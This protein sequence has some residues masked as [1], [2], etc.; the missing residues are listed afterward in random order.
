MRR[1]SYVAATAF[2]VCT[3]AAGARSFIVPH[4]IESSGAT[5]SFSTTLYSAY[6]GGLLGGTTGSAPVAIYLYDQL[7]EQPAQSLTNQDVCN[8]CSYQHN[9]HLRHESTASEAA[10]L[11]AGGFAS[12][13]LQG[14]AIVDVTGDAANV[15]LNGFLNN[16]RS[17]VFDFSSL[18]YAPVEIVS[19]PEAGPR[20]FV[21]PHLFESSATTS[22]P[23]AFDSSLYAVYAGGLPGAPPAGAGAQVALYLLDEDTQDFARSASFQQVCNPCTY[24]V[25]SGQRKARMS[26]QNAFVAAG[27]FPSSNARCFAVLVITG[28]A[29]L[30][31]IQGLTL[32]SRSS[33]FDLELIGVHA[34]EVEAGTLTDAAGGPPDVRRLLWNAP[35]PFNP[36]TRISYVVSKDGPVRLRIVDAAG[37]HVA[38]L[39]EAVR[40][41]GTHVVE[42]NGRDD[43]GRSVA[44]GAYFSRLETAAGGGTGKLVIVD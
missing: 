30:V 43:Q 24:P 7:T 18:G 34:M 23:N 11:T 3:N 37:R 1:T 39:V 44:A 33:P 5:F 21:F 19:N 4:V 40:P 20:A 26:L 8:P 32:Q 38:T 36:S 12:P 28:D 14:W 16:T 2:L 6:S 17:S 29:D 22:S 10:I 42:W 35:N 9:A 15:G 27:G 25:D 41:P 31:A 13:V